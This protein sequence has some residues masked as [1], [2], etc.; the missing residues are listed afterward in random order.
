MLLALR[1]T[2]RALLVI[3][4]VAVVREILRPAPTVETRPPPVATAMVHPQQ[5]FF[6]PPPEQP[7]PLRRV[8]SAFTE[9]AES[10]VGVVR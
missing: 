2:W 4:T 1:D 8:A 6:I 10:V 5:Q 7:R 9:L 3:A